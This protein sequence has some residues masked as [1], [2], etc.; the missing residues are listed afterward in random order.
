MKKFFV[1][2]HKSLKNEKKK[3]TCGRQC[4]S[5]QLSHCGSRTKPY[6]LNI[7]NIQNIYVKSLDEEDL[8]GLGI[9]P[10]TINGHMAAIDILKYKIKAFVL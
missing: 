3:C 7:Q 8:K 2:T 5:I 1:I 6:K 9:T 10:G 4:S